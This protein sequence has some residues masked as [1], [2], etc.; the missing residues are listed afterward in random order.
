M[1][2]I[3]RRVYL[4]NGAILSRCAIAGVIDHTNDG[5]DAARRL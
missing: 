3:A 1:A 2:A 4:G 5:P